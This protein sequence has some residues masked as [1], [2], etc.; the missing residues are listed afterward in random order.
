[1]AGFVIGRF[2]L[3]VYLLYSGLAGIAANTVMAQYAQTKGLPAAVA[4]PAV[5]LAH[6]LLLLAGFCFVAGWRPQLGVAAMVVFLLPVT[7]I[8]HAFWN[9]VPEQRVPQ[10]INFTKNMA[11][12][13]ACLMFL[14]IRRPW[15]YSLDGRRAQR[16]APPGALPA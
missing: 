14:A 12:M 2:I 13:G 11:L 5:F 15:P 6:L 7:F 1:M 4:G 9:A 3:G 8:M 16:Q 10:M